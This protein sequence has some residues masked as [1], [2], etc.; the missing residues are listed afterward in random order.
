MNIGQL[1]RE[2]AKEKGLPYDEE[3]HVKKNEARQEKKKERLAKFLEK[4]VEEVAPY[5]EKYPDMNVKQ[6]L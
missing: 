1:I 6:I 4:S 3:K 5:V 2:Y